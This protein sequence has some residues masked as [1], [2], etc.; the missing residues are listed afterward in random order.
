MIKKVEVNGKSYCF[1]KA[2]KGYNDLTYEQRFIILRA[3]EDLIKWNTSCSHDE[4][5]RD[6]PDLS[7]ANHIQNI[8]SYLVHGTMHTG[9]AVDR[10]NK[11]AN[12]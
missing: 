6:M 2:K 1:I 11:E 4:A 3:L 10:M 5:F 8:R 9:K 7:V 12:K